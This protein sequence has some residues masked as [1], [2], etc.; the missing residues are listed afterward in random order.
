[1]ETVTISLDKYER[2]IENEKK[3][4]SG[5]V[6]FSGYNMRFFWNDYTLLKEIILSEEEAKKI[7][8]EE[9]KKE[10][11]KKQM[12]NLMKKEKEIKNLEKSYSNRKK[13]IDEKEKRI[14]EKNLE[15]ILFKIWFFVLV[16]IVF[17]LSKL[18]FEYN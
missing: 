8:E 9:N 3:I 11:H 13:Q 7:N 5:H 4:I 6:E 16:F 1:M 2:L 12:D 10:Y 17:I 14:E 15:N 18:Y